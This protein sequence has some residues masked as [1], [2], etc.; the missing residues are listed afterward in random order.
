MEEKYHSITKISRVKEPSSNIVAVHTECAE[1]RKTQ[2]QKQNKK[3]VF[4]V[5]DYVKKKFTQ[6]KRAEHMWV[7][8]TKVS[9][10]Q[11]TLH[12]VL[13]N[14]P[15]IVINIKCGDKVNVRRTQIESYISN[16]LN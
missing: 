8:I 16:Q 3:L 4:Q 15:V 12:G 10:S 9:K 6:G 7:R 11:K 2:W 13:D 1:K 14:V 5:G